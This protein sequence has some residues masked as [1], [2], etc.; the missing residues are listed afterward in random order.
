MGLEK[1][2]WELV[3]ESSMNPFDCGE[4][5]VTKSLTARAVFPKRV[6]NRSNLLSLRGSSDEHC[7]ASS[8]PVLKELLDM[9]SGKY[10]G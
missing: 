7:E 8:D 2:S 6:H 5:H 3:V 4:L 1:Y 9:S 10:Q